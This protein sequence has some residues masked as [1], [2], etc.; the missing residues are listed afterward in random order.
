METPEVISYVERDG[1][2]IPYEE[3]DRTEQERIAGFLL[4]QFME[5]FGYEP[6]EKTKK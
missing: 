1:K 6:L 2:K 4:R 5:C 3:L